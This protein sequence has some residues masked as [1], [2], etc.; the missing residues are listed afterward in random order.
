[1]RL[2]RRLFHWY[3]GPL[4]AGSAFRGSGIRSPVFR[5]EQCIGHAPGTVTE[6]HYVPR[7]TSRTS[8]ERSALDRQMALFRRLVVEP[9]EQAT[10]AQ[11]V[12]GTCNI[13]QP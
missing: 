3:R 5:W 12:P 2:N 10:S 1:M 13:L 11:A 8:G 9:L 6:R 4:K 7:L